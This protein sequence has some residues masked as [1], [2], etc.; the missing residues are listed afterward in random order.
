RT[1]R[2]SCRCRK[3]SRPRPMS[4]AA[5]SPIR[6]VVLPAA[7]LGTRLRPLTQFMPKE[8]L[9]VGGR[10]V[11]QYVLD[12]CAEAGLDHVLA[13]LSSPK[14][15]LLGV[16][17]PADAPREAPQELPRRWIHAILQKSQRGLGH[18]ILHAE[19]FVGGDPFAVALPDT[20]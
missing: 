11:L 3:R 18:A 1:S 8:M 5:P 14:L 17:D 16:L 20:I 15:G 10:V 2:L 19:A 4:V 9:P 7:G 6:K 13:V 12:E